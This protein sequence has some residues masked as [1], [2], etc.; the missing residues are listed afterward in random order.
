MIPNAPHQTDPNEKSKPVQ[1]PGY[2]MAR[3]AR[4]LEQEGSSRKPSK[5]SENEKSIKQFRADADV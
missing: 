2:D 1:I 3:E 4:R 5:F